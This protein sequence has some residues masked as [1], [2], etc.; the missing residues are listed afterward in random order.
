MKLLGLIVLFVSAC[1]ASIGVVLHPIKCELSDQQVSEFAAAAGQKVGVEMASPLRSH[2]EI[3][4]HEGRLGYIATRYLGENRALEMHRELIIWMK[5]D[6]TVD[7]VHI[8]QSLI[9]SRYELDPVTAKP[10]CQN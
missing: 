10:D 2:V 3:Y 5:C 6:G 1:S 4:R 8:S 7:S 9:Y